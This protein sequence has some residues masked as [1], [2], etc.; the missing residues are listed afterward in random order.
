MSCQ[1]TKFIIDTLNDAAEKLRLY[2]NKD[3]EYV[4]GLLM[5][6]LLRD[7]EKSIEILEQ[8]K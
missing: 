6:V 8:E 5:D 3:Q 2:F 7:I 1:N 4:G